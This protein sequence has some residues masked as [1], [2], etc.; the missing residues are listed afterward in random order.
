VI[1]TV[2]GVGPDG[3]PYDGPIIIQNDP[4]RINTQTT[5][6]E[7]PGYPAITFLRDMNVFFFFRDGSNQAEGWK[8]Y[9]RVVTEYGTGD[10]QYLGGRQGKTDAQGRSQIVRLGTKQDWKKEDSSW[11]FIK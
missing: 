9:D 11:W 10:W 5:T 7:H 2:G 4:V 1:P 3:R 8:A 6:V